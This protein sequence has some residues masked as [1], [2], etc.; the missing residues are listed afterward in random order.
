MVWYLF[1]FGLGTF[2]VAN[3][4]PGFRHTLKTPVPCLQKMGWRT[5]RGE[6]FL[7]FTFVLMNIFWFVLFFKKFNE[8][9][10]GDP[11]AL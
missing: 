1:L 9:Y 3:Q 8:V 5:S 6:L 7:I 11:T 10:K 4:N 2:G